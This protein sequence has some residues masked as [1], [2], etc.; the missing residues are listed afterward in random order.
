[1]TDRVRNILVW[2]VVCEEGSVTPSQGIPMSP[3]ANNPAL[4][5]P[6][7]IVTAARPGELSPLEAAIMDACNTLH[8]ARAQGDTGK[9]DALRSTLFDLLARYD[10]TDG[11]HHPA[12]AWARPNQRALVHSAL[13]E[14]REAIRLEVAALR[15]ADTPRRKEISLGNLAERC[16]RIGEHLKAVDYFLKAWEIAPDSVPVMV[17]GAQALFF[18]GMP[19]EADHIFE[20]LETRPELLA[21]DGELGAYLQYESRLISMS[22]VLPAL[23][24]LMRHWHQVRAR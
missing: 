5:V 23:G 7:T 8:E 24:R 3:A 19:D 2:S 10:A 4:T 13:G 20:A 11:E 14:V 1:M 6:A 16:I 17:T 18:A 22:V 15:Y 12:P 21:P 9:V